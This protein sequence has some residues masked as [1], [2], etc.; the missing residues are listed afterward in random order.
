M[1]EKS[2]MNLFMPIAEAMTEEERL[3]TAYRLLCSGSF[4]S[5]HFNGEGTHIIFED[6]NINV[7]E[8]ELKFAEDITVAD[9][10][11]GKDKPGKSFIGGFIMAIMTKM[12][13]RNKMKVVLMSGYS[14]FGGYG[15]SLD[16][17]N[18][19][20]YE[21]DEYEKLKKTE[22]PSS[23]AKE[24]FEEIIKMAKNDE[25]SYNPGTF[26]TDNIFDELMK[27][28]APILRKTET[29]NTIMNRLGDLQA[30]G[31]LKLKV[32]VWNG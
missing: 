3:R 18:V 17:F 13:L 12:N 25:I 15:N 5:W 26:S 29:H 31:L 30:M 27:P 24:A 22:T 2:V 21:E 4:M 32:E 1:E 14:S 10:T 6:G 19:H 7:G 11:T 20:D 16:I 9:L 28:E 8:H 23:L